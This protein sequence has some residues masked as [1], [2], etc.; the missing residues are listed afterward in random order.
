MSISVLSHADKH[1]SHFQLVEL[2]WSFVVVHGSASDSY[3]SYLH[4]PNPIF[5]V[6]GFLQSSLDSN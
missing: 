3:F 6:K 4:L 1:V 2:L 5:T